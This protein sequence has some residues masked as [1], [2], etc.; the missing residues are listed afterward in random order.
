MFVF[1]ALIIQ[2]AER[3]RCVIAICGRSGCA[4]VLLIIS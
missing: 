1:V 4:V 2:Q 3:M